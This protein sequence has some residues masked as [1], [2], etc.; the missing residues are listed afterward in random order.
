MVSVCVSVCVSVDC[1]AMK[2]VKQL[3]ELD[4][5]FSLAWNSA[6]N[7]HTMHGAPRPLS[8]V[9]KVKVASLSKWHSRKL[10]LVQAVG[11]F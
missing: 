6:E 7:G 4:H 5:P 10:M 8:A 1:Y 9:T 2:F 11:L 3:S